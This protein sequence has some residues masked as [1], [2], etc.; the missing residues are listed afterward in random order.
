[1]GD[2][3]VTAFRLEPG[4]PH[5]SGTGRIPGSPDRPGKKRPADPG[6]VVKNSKD[7]KGL[8]QPLLLLFRGIYAV[9]ISLSHSGARR[10]V[11]GRPMSLDLMWQ[12]NKTDSRMNRQRAF[13]AVPGIPG[14]KV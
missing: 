11:S 6:Q 8:L 10:N 9:F 14:I 13:R 7:L 4:D 2:A 12:E 3:V 1:M 5:P